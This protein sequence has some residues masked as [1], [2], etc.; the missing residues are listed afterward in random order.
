MSDEFGGFLDRE[1]LLGGSPEKRAGTLLFLI[2]TR[3][4]KLAA[5][6]RQKFARP[7]TEASA[8]ERALEFVEAFSAAREDAV[9][10]TVGDLERQADRWASMVPANPRLQAALAR[11]IGAKYRFTAALAPA[12]R[13][14]LGLD[15]P[16]V[17][18]AYRD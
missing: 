10:P 15:D 1:Q 4:V 8:Q 3:A 13:K 17:G 6:A 7:L 11:R 2:E 16:A 9:R 12:I 14:A 5:Q 18:E